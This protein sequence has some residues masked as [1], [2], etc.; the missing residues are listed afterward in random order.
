VIVDLSGRQPEWRADV[1]G[2]VADRLRHAV[3]R[4]GASATPAPGGEPALREA[5]ATLLDEPAER[6][7]ITYGVRAAA[8]ILGRGGRAYV[9]RPTFRGVPRVFTRLGLP[10]EHFAWDEV[11]RLDLAS[12][13][14]CWITSPA[15]NPDGAT[16]ADNHLNAL[17]AAA[18]AGGHV[19]QNEI[20]RWYAPDAPTVRSAFRVGSLSKLVGGGVRLGWIV[21]PDDDAAALILDRLPVGPPTPWQ[22]AWAGLL[23]GGADALTGW[24]ID[25]PREA[26]AAFFEAAGRIGLPVA[27]ATAGPSMMI[28]LAAAADEQEVVARLHR[29]GVIV[30]AGADFHAAVPS[31]RLCFTTVSPEEATMAAHRLAATLVGHVPHDGADRTG[32]L[33]T[34]ARGSLDWGRR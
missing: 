24:S 20:Y 17:E 1:A 4:P 8:E 15:R 3:L 26:K 18:R 21:A 12:G 33:D 28:A 25:A 10:V 30:G 34:N 13:D 6:I 27:R 2:E 19:V 11:P 22:R 29:A 7:V 23:G 9:E 16:L 31:I 5:L 14:I 32:E